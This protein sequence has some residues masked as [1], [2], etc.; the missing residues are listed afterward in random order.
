MKIN[1]SFNKKNKN[2]NKNEDKKVVDIFSLSD[3]EETFDFENNQNKKIEEEKKK[4]IER[5]IK[6]YI[7]EHEN[8]IKE[9][10]N[11]KEPEKNQKE[12]K[13]KI[14]YLGYKGEE[15]TK[16]NNEKI[17]TRENRICP[18]KYKKEG[19]RN[20]RDE[21]QKCDKYYKEEYKGKC[22]KSKNKKHGENY[23]TKNMLNKEEREKDISIDEIFMKKDNNQTNKSKYMNALINSTKRRALEKEILIQK[24]LKIDTK[25]EEKV[26]ITNAYRKK[27]MDRELIKK[28]IE[29]QK[30]NIRDTQP[31]YNL[32]LFLKN[33][34]IPSSYN[35][36]NRKSYY[37]TSNIS[38]YE[39]F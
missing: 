28:D 17:N 12:G 25:K 24:K 27:M 22:E 14:L 21:D 5:E 4:E 35:R 11:K 13:K 3:D 10:C 9:K 26:F 38:D 18:Q 2:E 23:E 33:M 7:Y 6:E 34:N 37:D 32:N 15:L 30:E 1:F 31:N 29:E 20:K 36:N 39:K 19:E 16:L 8:P